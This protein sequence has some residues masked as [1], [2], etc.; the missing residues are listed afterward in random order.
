MTGGR[1]RCTAAT[2]QWHATVKAPIAKT[3]RKDDNGTSCDQNTYHC[4]WREAAGGDGDR[5]SKT[6]C[7][8][9]LGHDSKED[10]LRDEP[11]KDTRHGHQWKGDAIRQLEKVGLSLSHL[12]RGDAKRLSVA[13]KPT[14]FVGQEHAGTK[15]IQRQIKKG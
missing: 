13:P 12:R 10:A 8:V 9:V 14:P 7:L 3:D 15:T 11:V 1:Y 4:K 5:V 2:D 6:P